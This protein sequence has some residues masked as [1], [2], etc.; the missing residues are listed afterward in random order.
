MDEEVG[1]AL[2]LVVDEDGRVVLVLDEPASPEVADALLVAGRANDANLVEVDSLLDDIGGGCLLAVGEYGVSAEQDGVEEVVVVF[3]AL[4]QGLG[5]D[6]TGDGAEGVEVGVPQLGDGLVLEP[7]LVDEQ[8]VDDASP[9]VLA[10]RLLG[11]LDDALGDDAA[12][13]HRHLALLH[14]AWDALLDQVA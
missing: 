9:V 5:D 12:V 11:G 10:A 13:C 6:T 7:A 2:V 1:V 4:D 8:G 3:L 14:L